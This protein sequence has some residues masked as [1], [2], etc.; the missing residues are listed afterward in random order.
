MR[1][2]YRLVSR[3]KSGPRFSSVDILVRLRPAYLP[4]RDQRMGEA[5]VIGAWP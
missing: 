4:E 5:A 3:R 1:S 2:G